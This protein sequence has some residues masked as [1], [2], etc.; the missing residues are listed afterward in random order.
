[1]M[2]DQVIDDDDVLPDWTSSSSRPPPLPTEP[3][4]VKVPQDVLA[5]VSDFTKS[6]E[7]VKDLRA[8]LKKRIEEGEAHVNAMLLGSY[9][10]LS[11]SQHDHHNLSEVRKMIN[12]CAAVNEDLARFILH[13]EDQFEGD[14]EGSSM[15]SVR[16]LVTFRAALTSSQEKLRAA[17]DSIRWT[18]LWKDQQQEK[19]GSLIQSIERMESMM[20]MVDFRLQDVSHGVV[21]LVDAHGHDVS[22]FSSHILESR[23]EE[24]IGYMHQISP[25]QDRVKTEWKRSARALRRQFRPRLSLLAFEE[26]EERIKHKLFSQQR[27]IVDASELE[28]ELVQIALEDVPMKQE[29]SAFDSLV[30]QIEAFDVKRVVKA[31]PP[32][33]PPPP[34]AP[35]VESLP[36]KV[37]SASADTLASKS[38]DSSSK[39]SKQKSFG[40]AREETESNKKPTFQKSELTSKP[41]V[42]SFGSFGSPSASSAFGM[43]AAAATSATSAPSASPFA[44]TSTT[45]TAPPQATPTLFSQPAQSQSAGLSTQARVEE[46]YRKHNPDKLHEVPGILKKYAGRESE[47]LEKLEKKYLSAT[48]SQQSAPQNKPPVF[49]SPNPAVSPFPS[50]SA[51][52]PAAPAAAPT[53]FGQSPA[54]LFKLSPGF[55]LSSAANNVAPASQGI[56]GFGGFGSSPAPALTPAANPGAMS[57]Q[58]VARRVEKFYRLHNPTKLG[59]IPQLMEKYKGKEQQ[60]LANLEKKYGASSA[61]AAATPSPAQA[62][63]TPFSAPR[64]PTTSLFGSTARATPFTSPST[65]A[66]ATPGFGTSPMTT[67]LFGHRQQAAAPAWGTGGMQQTFGNSPPVPTWGR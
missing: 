56:Q 10:L 65:P 11:Q 59:D 45:N 29:P 48:P 32:P 14:L 30:K 4:K 6:R 33:P 19:T 3:S 23:S 25:I 26:E 55:G 36:S 15:R 27:L 43:T 51:V 53:P 58:D 52:T 66:I 16:D 63:M 12:I 37:S 39:E 46:I 13:V 49:G 24:K 41:S 22:F 60:L 20:T 47:L 5:N 61:A 54:P 7:A 8:L 42:P 62:P 44:A 1:M 28:E 67:S 17:K 34:P 2:S 64:G 38:V 31:P 50:S 40:E 57:V 9:A 21:D 35:V 18:A